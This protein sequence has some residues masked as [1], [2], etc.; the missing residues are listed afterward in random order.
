MRNAMTSRAPGGANN[1]T[2]SIN[3]F[4]KM[5]S[6]SSKTPIIFGVRFVETVCSFYHKM[7][8]DPDAKKQNRTLLNTIEHH[9]NRLYGFMGLQSKMLEWVSGVGEWSGWMDGYPLDCYDY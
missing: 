3:Q 9:G 4:A 1:K 5:H 6:L 8:V 7:K 2:C